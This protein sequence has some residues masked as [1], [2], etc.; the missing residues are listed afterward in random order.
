MTHN[1][2]DQ[3]RVK[4]T[5]EGRKMLESERA[6][7]TALVPS[8]NW[9]NWNRPDK[10][11]WLRLQFHA[12]MDAFGKGNWQMGFG[13]APFYEIEFETEENLV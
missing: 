3:C 8:M 1:I 9:V 6:R 7:L 10:D 11:G 13:P 12:V 2:N 4:L 5:E